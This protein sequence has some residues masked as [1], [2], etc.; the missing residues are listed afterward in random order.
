[1]KILIIKTHKFLLIFLFIFTIISCDPLEERIK[2]EKPF[3]IIEKNDYN[4]KQN[5]IFCKYG[6]QDVNGN[7]TIFYD[8]YTKYNI[9]DS[10][11]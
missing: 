9:G 2:F 11:K 5:I 10:I 1:M 4:T 3:I 7:R 8:E 6:Y